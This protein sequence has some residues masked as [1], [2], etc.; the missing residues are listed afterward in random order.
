MT[1]FFFNLQISK[2]KC[3][4]LLAPLWFHG[5]SSETWKSEK[6]RSKKIRENTKSKIARE[7]V[8]NILSKKIV[9]LSSYTGRAN[10]FLISKKKNCQIEVSGGKILYR[11]I[12]VKIITTTYSTKTSKG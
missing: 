11:Y 4:I 1:F 9:K 8:I 12:V 3:E 6:T 2:Y 10:F 7:I 5:K